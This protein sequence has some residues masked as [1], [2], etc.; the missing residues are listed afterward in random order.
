[1]LFLAIVT[2]RTEWN[3]C[4]EGLVDRPEDASELDGSATG[5][6]YCLPPCGPEVSVSCGGV[7][8]E[9]EV[10]LCTAAGR[11]SE[12]AARARLRAATSDPGVTC[13]DSDLDGVCDD[14]SAGE[15]NGVDEDCDGT[16]DDGYVPVATTVDDSDITIPVLAEDF[17]FPISESGTCTVFGTIDGALTCELGAVVPSVQRDADFCGATTERW[18]PSFGMEVPPADWVA[19]MEV[20]SL[21]EN[22]DPSNWDNC[23]GFGE[24][25]EG[26]EGPLRIFCDGNYAGNVSEFPPGDDPLLVGTDWDPQT[27]TEF[28]SNG[29]PYTVGNPHAMCPPHMYCGKTDNPPPGHAMSQTARAYCIPIPDCSAC[30]AVVND[31]NPATPPWPPSTGT[32]TPA[33]E[34]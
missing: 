29:D 17:T 21:A 27:T 7:E 22:T 20:V 3:V 18:I 5:T 31:G 16:A 13:V 25:T 1:M 4:G 32:C 19:R 6:R 30:W 26:Y 24:G 14:E 28:D 34:E 10:R 23:A 9:P 2:R 8:D 15:C 11:E 12:A 33:T